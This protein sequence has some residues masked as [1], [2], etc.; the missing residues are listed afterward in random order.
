M[1]FQSKDVLDAMVKD[2]GVT[3]S[4]IKV[5]GGAATNNFLLQFQ[6]DILM[7]NIERGKINECTALGAA[8][9]AGLCCSFW[10]KEDLNIELDRVFKPVR[11]KENVE[12]IYAGWKRAV[13]ACMEF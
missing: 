4:A 1:A 11:T 10:K 7:C 5:D 9:L 6:S 13:H 12:Q 3:L 2:S 8:Y